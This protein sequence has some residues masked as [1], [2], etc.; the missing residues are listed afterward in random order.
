MGSAEGREGEEAGLSIRRNQPLVP[1]H[2]GRSLA[3]SHLSCLKE[4]HSFTFI[5]RVFVCRMHMNLCAVAHRQ[6]TEDHFQESVSFYH[7][8]PGMMV[9]VSR[10]MGAGD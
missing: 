4:K 1:L 10:Y 6:R 9:V 8:V 3:I 7:D 2:L 5:I